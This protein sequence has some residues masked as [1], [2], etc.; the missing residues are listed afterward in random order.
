MKKIYILMVICLLITG[1]GS[2]N[3]MSSNSINTISVD[4]VKKHY[5]DAVK[6]EY[7]IDDIKEQKLYTEIFAKVKI[8][9]G[10]K[11]NTLCLLIYEH[12]VFILSVYNFP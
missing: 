11:K 5:N 6:K 1:C 2:D 4:E 3:K 8:T 12:N 7:L 9:K 10:E